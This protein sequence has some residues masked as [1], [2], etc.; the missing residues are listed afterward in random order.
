MKGYQVI[1]SDDEVLGEVASIDGDL[2]IVEHRHLL[3]EH[4]YA[5]PKAFAHADDSE[6]VVRLTV[7]KP[8]VE[9][10]PEVTD[11]EL[12]RD[13]IAAHYGLVDTRSPELDP[14]D[15]EGTEEWEEHRLG[16]EPAAERRAKMLRSEESPGPRGRQIIPS[17]SHE[18]L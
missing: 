1:T 13:A 7:S 15:P 11:G 4:H 14:D 16:R 12:D 10:A 3:K 18:K 6:N 5:I 8:L 9:D 2:I 17:D